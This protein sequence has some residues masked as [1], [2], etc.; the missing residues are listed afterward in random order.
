MAKSIS[1]LMLLMAVIPIFGQEVPLPADFRQHNLLSINS[2]LFNPVF[3][4]R[5]D[6]RHRIGLWTRWQWQTIDGDPTTLLLN[7][8]GKFDGFALG[9]GL[10]QNNNRLFQHT[11]G[12]VNFA[13]DFRITDEFSVAAGFNAF[14]YR[15]ELTDNRFIIQ[16][17][18]LPFPEDNQDFII[19]VAPA[20]E[21][22]YNDLGVG[23]VFENLFDYSFDYQEAVSRSDEKIVIGMARYDFETGGGSAASPD[24]F[25][26]MVYFKKIPGFDT[27]IG[28]NGIFNASRY[29]I[30]GGYN[31]FY[32]PSLGAGG[33]FLQHLSIGGVVEFASDNAPETDGLSYELVLAYD[34]GKTDHRKKVVGFDVEEDL[35]REAELLAARE[36]AEEAARRQERDSLAAAREAEAAGVAAA[37]EAEAARMAAA[38]RDS[39]ETARRQE[40]L[41]AQQRRRDS[42]SEAERALALQEEDVTPEAGEKYQ[43]ITREGQL[44]PGYYLI[45]NVFGTKRYYDAFMEKLR[46]Q[47]LEPQ[48]FYRSRNKYNYVYLRRYDNI[49][50]ARQARDSKFSGRYE[51]DLWILRIR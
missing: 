51:G 1:A 33:R 8:T 42:I 46:G 35:K 4:L 20:I 40:E 22:K 25:T 32:G 6:P 50:E 49:S 11:G 48:S 3:S 41:L 45:A 16:E 24:R 47:G 28:L 5:Q 21:L 7:Y 36:Q 14:A 10:F 34:F 38:R 27:Q 19:Q 12:M 37:R 29:W 15:Q 30:Q 9:G 31:S 2:S 23:F 26:P 43:E 17:P 13:Y 39:I 18:I 44:E